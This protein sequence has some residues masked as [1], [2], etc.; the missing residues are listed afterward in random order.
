[1]KSAL[2]KLPTSREIEEIEMQTMTGEKIIETVKTLYRDIA[3]NTDLDT[4][5]FLGIQKAFTRFKDELVLNGS[6]ITEV[7][8]QIKDIKTELD[9]TRDPQD[10]KE[11][12]DR[13]KDLVEERKVRL[14]IASQNKKQLSSQIARIRDTFYDFC[15]DDLSLKE[16]IKL[17]FREHGLTITAVIIATGTI[18]STLILS[19]TGGAGVSSG[20]PKPNKGKE[21]VKK[22]LKDFARL[23]GRLAEQVAKALPNAI[24]S[25]FAA[26]LNLFQKVA[27]AAANY[28]WVFLTGIGSVIGYE[29][30]KYFNP[31]SKN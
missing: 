26:I 23:L 8:E 15:E 24:G 2:E 9:N 5:E 16:K 20:P 25:L 18:I 30:Y 11:L 27:L 10:K 3:V 21:W 17:I 31:S 1:M 29:I 19:L 4:R 12:K 28:A 13:L 22:K 6:K 7:D 14:E